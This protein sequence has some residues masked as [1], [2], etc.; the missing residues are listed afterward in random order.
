[1]TANQNGGD[2]A[3]GRVREEFARIANIVRA[4]PATIFAFQLK[5]DGS[6]VFPYADESIEDFYG[7]SPSALAVDAS[8]VFGFIHPEDV[9]NVQ[10]SIDESARDLTSWHSEWRVLRD[11]T[12]RW[13][14]GRS[15]PTKQPDGSIVWHGYIADIS[16]RKRT[17]RALRESEGRLHQL[18]ESVTDYAIFLVDAAGKIIT[19]NNG[20]ER[21]T[22][23]SESDAIGKEYLSIVPLGPKDEP[24]ADLLN[25]AEVQ[26]KAVIE[27]WRLHKSGVRYWSFGTLT[28]L[29]AEDG[30][31]RGYSEVS[32]DLTTKKHNEELLQSVLDHTLDGIVRIDA[33]G[34][35]ATMNHAGEV[36]FGYTADEVIGKNVKMLMPEPYRS[37]HDGY[38]TNYLT[39][40]VRKIIGIGRE[41]QGLRKEGKAFPLD[42][43]VTEFS[44]YGQRQ[45]VAIIRDISERKTLEA[46]L[47][48]AQ[49]MEA[50][51]QLAGGIAHDFNNLLTVIFGNVHLLE[52][53]LANNENKDLLDEIH[54]ASK[55]AATLTHQLLAF[56]RQQVLE[57]KVVNLNEIVQEMEK[58]LGRLIGEDVALAIVLDPKAS[59]VRVDPGQIDQVIVNLAVNARDAMP[60]GGKL[61]I[62]T[63]NVDLD[64]SYTKMHVEARPGK[65]V[66]LAITDTGTGMTPEVQERAFEPFY[67]TKPI[68]EGSGLGLSVVH[69]IVKQS[70]GAINL[71]SEIGEGTC[72]KIFLPAVEDP[73]AQA[74]GAG[75]KPIPTGTETILLV[76]DEDG[77]RRLAERVLRAAGYT[78]I[79][80]E[81]G[82]QAIKVFDKQGA[83][84]DLVLTD[85]VMPGGL[86]GREVVEHVRKNL[87]SVKVL[88]MSGYTSDAVVRHG[89]L[90]ADVH[91]MQKPFTPDSLATKVRE[92]LDQNPPKRLDQA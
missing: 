71:Y 72:I 70:G 89:V 50:F 83:D 22:G 77:V 42:L 67:T 82:A 6:V 24:Q 40:G 45:F 61:T 76:E 68:G 88:Y 38:L 46:Q 75:P 19:W 41:V 79:A 39:T 44:F 10:K 87:P 43:A 15:T 18:I 92:V 4:M 58:L 29:F 32:R 1:M 64:D 51:G 17:E 73:R 62:E 21:L 31:L 90:A 54:N 86:S 25:R 63:A 91:F 23:Y 27:G 11:G 69:G 57:P 85:V 34:T 47:R 28:A 12:E 26:G 80:A 56:S 13:V 2:P 74:F 60:R 8:P 81:N 66:M 20:A 7:I 35:I 9:A 48:Q 84:I 55:R 5:P 14:E 37:E 59:R 53:V 30:S 52:S 33:H 78:L 65:Y 49:K 16:E 3:D 36:I